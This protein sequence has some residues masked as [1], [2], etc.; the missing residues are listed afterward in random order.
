[1]SLPTSYFCRSAILSSLENLFTPSPTVPFPSEIY[2]YGNHNTGKLTIVKQALQ[3]QRAHHFLLDCR[4]IYSLNMFYQ[5]FISSLPLKQSF[6]IPNMKSF[7]DFVRALRD[8][9]I[10]ES[11]GKK[12]KSKTHFFVVIHHLEILLNYDNSGHLLYLLFKLNE[13]TFGNFPHT[14]VLIGHQ[15]FY[16]LPQI[17]QIE[18]ELGVLTPISIFVPAYTKQEIVSILQQII[19][20]KNKIDEFHRILSD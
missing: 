12:K 13:L 6:P 7:H 18:A 3:N 4:E 20:R 14:L 5:S 9:S 2:L 16:Q 17:N 11:N 1:M 15:P 10:D 19:T 8:F